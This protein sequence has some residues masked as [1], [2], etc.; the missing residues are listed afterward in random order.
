MA[1][2]VALLRAV[3]VGGTGKLPMTELRA[4]CE[5]IGFANVRTYISSGNVVFST[6]ASETAV[7]TALEHAL[8]THAG[9]PVGV[10]VRTSAEIAAVVTASPFAAAAGNRAIA[11][12]LDEPPPADVL[13]GVTMKRSRLAS[14]KSMSITRAAWDAPN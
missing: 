14:A 5:A 8:E 12:F 9:K 3:N 11:I 10:M 2:Y 1:M 13:T 6:A 7:K 4:M